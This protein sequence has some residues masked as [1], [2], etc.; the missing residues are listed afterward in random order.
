[1]EAE[2]RLP[3]RAS[4]LVAEATLSRRSAP[5]FGVLE[6]DFL[7]LCSNQMASSSSRESCGDGVDIIV[8]KR[9]CKE[10]TFSCEHQ[11]AIEKVATNR[12]FKFLR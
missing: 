6:F 1:L 5:K 10:K 9:T 11:R 3:D 7:F 4:K 2:P 12:K 8:M